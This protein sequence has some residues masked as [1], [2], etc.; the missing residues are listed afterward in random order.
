MAGS[1][2]LIQLRNEKRQIHPFLSYGQLG[3]PVVQ[4]GS[5]QVQNSLR[6]ESEFRGWPSLYVKRLSRVSRTHVTL[7]YTSKLVGSVLQA[8]PFFSF[9]HSEYYQQGL[10][11]VSR[12]VFR[13]SDW[14]CG[15][16]WQDIHMV[17]TH[18]KKSTKVRRS[19]VWAIW[20]DFG[21]GWWLEL[22]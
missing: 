2:C 19:R 4:V 18:F 17:R 11:L 6:E 15:H 14:V 10:H 3:I 13:H 7:S 5:A 9:F 12:T 21:A 22:G 1:T 20:V 16:F 8:N